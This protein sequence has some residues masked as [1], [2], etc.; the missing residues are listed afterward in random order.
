MELPEMQSA[1]PHNS[2]GDCICSGSGLLE[3]QSLGLAEQSLYFAHRRRAY[4]AAPPRARPPAMSTP[5]SRAVLSIAIGHPRRSASMARAAAL[6]SA[7][8]NRIP[9]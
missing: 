3:G 7:L 6:G 4:K 2:C 9:S 8:K 5:A 1:S